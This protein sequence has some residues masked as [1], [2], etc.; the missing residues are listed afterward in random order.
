METPQ[1]VP[2]KFGG[3]APNNPR[4]LPGDQEAGGAD[5]ALGP[6]PREADGQ[7]NDTA[8]AD[9]EF[10]QASSARSFDDNCNLL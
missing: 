7:A 6:D 9:V 3:N 4:K 8:K 2:H 5:Q 1:R 10:I